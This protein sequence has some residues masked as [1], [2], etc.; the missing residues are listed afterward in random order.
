MRIGTIRDESRSPREAGGTSEPDGPAGGRQRRGG[1]LGSRRSPWG[2][3]C[4]IRPPWAGAQQQVMQEAG[5]LSQS[6]GPASMSAALHR[7]WLCAGCSSTW[8][9]LCS[10]V[11]VLPADPGALYTISAP[12]SC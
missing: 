8:S 9:H 2:W 7:L 10:P 6:S 12:G 11:E 1:A 3:R 5:Y 4:P